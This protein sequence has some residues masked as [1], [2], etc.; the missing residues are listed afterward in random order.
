M[1]Q[2]HVYMAYRHFEAW[3]LGQHNLCGLGLRALGQSETLWNNIDVLRRA[4]D[5]LKK[6]LTNQHLM[7]F[8]SKIW[9]GSGVDGLFPNA[10]R[11]HS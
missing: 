3:I 8:Q 2:L 11:Y 5:F 9:C 6:C 1:C 7:S 4:K 10:P